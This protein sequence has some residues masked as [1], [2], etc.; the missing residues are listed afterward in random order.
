MEHKKIGDTIIR[1]AL[2]VCAPLMVISIAALFATARS[3]DAQEVQLKYLDAKTIDVSRAVED[4]REMI[5]DIRNTVNSM[6][7]DQEAFRARVEER[8]KNF[9]AT[10]QSK[11]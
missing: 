8:L 11:K 3:V 9:E 10:L 5:S 4:I 1:F 2:G 7:I 6:R